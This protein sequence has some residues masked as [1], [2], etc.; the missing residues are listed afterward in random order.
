VLEIVFL[1]DERRRDQP[2]LTRLAQTVEQLPLLALGRLLG[3][4]QRL[5]L[6]AA[7]E[8][9]IA[10]DDLGLLRGF[11]L[12]HANRAPLF[13]PLVQ[14]TRKALLELDRCADGRDPQN[15]SER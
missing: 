12:A 14:V 15:G 3:L 11:L 5:E 9:G 7:E 6:P 2:A 13:G 8:V 10:P 1:L 4:A